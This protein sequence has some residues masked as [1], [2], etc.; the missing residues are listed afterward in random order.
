MCIVVHSTLAINSTRKG[1]EMHINTLVGM[2]NVHTL[3]CM[4]EKDKK[5]TSILW[6]RKLAFNYRGYSLK[7]VLKASKTQLNCTKCRI[8]EHRIHDI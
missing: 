3:N 4:A 1:V 2:C 7:K 8:K 5:T 6:L